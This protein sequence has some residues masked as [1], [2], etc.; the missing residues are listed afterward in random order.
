MREKDWIDFMK[1]EQSDTDHDPLSQYDI[2]NFRKRNYL[3]YRDET[4]SAKVRPE[5]KEQVKSFSEFS[6]PLRNMIR[7][8]LKDDQPTLTALAKERV[9][10][11]AEDRNFILGGAI[12]AHLDE[13]PLDFECQELYQSG[14]M[15]ELMNKLPP[16]ASFAIAEAVSGLG[17]NDVMTLL[18]LTEVVTTRLN[19]Y[20]KE[21]F[22]LR[23]TKNNL[24]PVIILR[25][26][27]RVL[28]SGF[29]FPHQ[30]AIKLKD[31]DI[32]ISI[33]EDD[34]EDSM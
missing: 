19:G 12:L 32:K 8:L 30:E 14:K 9:I 2:A 3:S 10:M 34:A 26:G 31:I 22:W 23:C 27:V 11:V 5:E 20:E 16:P 6:E 29:Q 13:L 21:I 7:L 1:E 15:G 4:I 24:P 33:S 17:R 28:A 18:N 25:V